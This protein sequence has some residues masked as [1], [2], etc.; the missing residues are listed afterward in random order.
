[1]AG[2][3]RV[4]LS[5]VVEDCGVKTSN[6]VAANFLKIKCSLNNLDP[7]A[8]NTSKTISLNFDNCSSTL[9]T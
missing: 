9:I 2:P 5:E 7:A 3:N 4:G 6:V 1:M 8:C